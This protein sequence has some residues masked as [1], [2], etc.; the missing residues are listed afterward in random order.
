MVQDITVY[1]DAN[2][3]VNV[4]AS[5]IDNG[6]TDDFSTTN[7]LVLALDITSF[8]CSDIGANTVVFTATDENG[9]S[10]SATA[11]VTVLDNIVPSVTTVDIM[12]D[13]GLNTNITITPQ[14]I[15]GAATDNCTIS[16]MTLDQDTFTTV[17]TYTVT[18][19]VTDTSNNQTMVTAIVTVEDTMNTEDNT[20]E[21]LKIYPNPT[22]NMVTVSGIKAI[23]KLELYTLQGQKVGSS[24]TNQ[25][26][27]NQ[28]IP[29]VYI[30][31]VINNEKMI[32][33]KI[34]KN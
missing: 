32:S 24:T 6:T 18:L 8:D 29:G 4:T 9:N 26:N 3:Q 5:D 19:T 28:L 34:I 11:T 7:N 23:E 12:L 31:K 27:T 22:T 2:E 14:D 16:T 25:I 13:L 30:L 21:T 17:G 33:S 1:L 15:L 20:L 10:D